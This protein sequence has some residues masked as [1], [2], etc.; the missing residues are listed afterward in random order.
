MNDGV[1]RSNPRISGSDFTSVVERIRDFNVRD[2]N[3]PSAKERVGRVR[4]LYKPRTAK[5][6]ITRRRN[7]TYAVDRTGA[8]VNGMPGLV[9]G[10]STCTGCAWGLQRYRDGGGF[11]PPEDVSRFMFSSRVYSCNA[12]RGSF[13]ADWRRV[14]TPECQ[15]GELKRISSAGRLYRLNPL[16]LLERENTCIIKTTLLLRLLLLLLLDV[17]HRGPLVRY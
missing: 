11:S 5:I 16:I 3:G 13:G 15:P 6:F 8:G 1:A 17:R 4:P 7:T 12:C 14:K 2:E 9:L 10:H